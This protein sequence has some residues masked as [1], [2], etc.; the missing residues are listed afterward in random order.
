MAVVLLIVAAAAVALGGGDDEAAPP[1]P[2]RTSTTTSTVPPTITTTTQPPTGPVAPLTGLRVADPGKVLRP[3]IAVK[4]DNLDASAETAVP[5]SGLPHAD[6]VF[7][8]IVEGNITRL[9]AVFHSQ[10]PGRVGPVR[11][12]RT[13]DVHLLP[14]LRPRP[15]RVVGGN[16]GVV[17]AVRSC[18]ALVDLGSF[19][20]AAHSYARDRSRRAPHNLFVQAD[21]LWGKAPEGV[22]APPPLFQF[23]APGQVNQAGALVSAGVDITW[24]GGQASSPVNWRWEPDCGSTFAATR[25]TARGRGR[26]APSP[27]RTWWC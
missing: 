7:E 27:P 18:A 21:E 11:S 13:T 1:P 3:S 22:P 2:K 26:H 4:V 16:D 15:V 12:A 25:P 10:D 23:R 19:S 5:Q 24:G 14:G 9:V 6:V 17:G 8:E 20:R